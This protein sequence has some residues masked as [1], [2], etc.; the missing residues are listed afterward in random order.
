MTRITETELHCIG[1]ENDIAFR[2][3]AEICAALGMPFPPE[4]REPDTA[5]RDAMADP[6][7]E[8]ETA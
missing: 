1:Q 7:T 4:K 3:M 2:H 5:K 8:S 6:F